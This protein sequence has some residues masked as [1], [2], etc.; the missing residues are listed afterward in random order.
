MNDRAEA[1]SILRDSAVIVFVNWGGV[2]F[3]LR[4]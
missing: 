3:E 4:A 1:S 2:N